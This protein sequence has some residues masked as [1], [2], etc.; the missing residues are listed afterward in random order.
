MHKTTECVYEYVTVYL[1]AGLT[2]VLFIH[3]TGCQQDF[4]FLPSAKVEDMSG[5]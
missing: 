3:C 1:H 5:V 4:R 2:S